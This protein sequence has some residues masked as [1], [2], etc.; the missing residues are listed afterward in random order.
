V[1]T[2]ASSF[3]PVDSNDTIRKYEIRLKQYAKKG[4]QAYHS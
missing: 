4:Q 3:A 2:R 1:E